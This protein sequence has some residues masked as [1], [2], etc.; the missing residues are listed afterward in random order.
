MYFAKICGLNFTMYHV[1]KN[2]F[3]KFLNINAQRDSI[4]ILCDSVFKKNQR[5]MQKHWKQ[6]PTDEQTVKTLQEALQIHPT[7]CELLAQRG[8]HDFEAARTYFRPELK[9]LHDPYEML[10]MERAVQRILQAIE[11]QEKI[12]IYGDYDV[13]GTT[14]VALMYSFLA[15]VHKHLDYYIPDRYKEGYGLSYQGIEYAKQK[16][17]GLLIT[18]DCGIR[19]TSEVRAAQHE[20]IDVIICDHH[21][22]GETLPE[23]HAILDPKQVDCAYPYKE[24][25]G[26]G[27]GF[28]LVQ[29][30]C[31][32][33]ELPN[34]RWL[35]LMDFLVISIAADIVPITGEN[36]ILAH[37]G[38][39]Q[40]NRTERIGL[41][42]LAGKGGKTFPLSISDIVFGIAPIVNAAGRLADAEQAVRLLLANTKQ[43]AGDLAN[44]LELR[45]KMRREFDERTSR[46]AKE[47]FEQLPDKES[48][49]S[50]CLFHPHWHKGV[51][52]ITASRMVEAFY[53]P[54]IILTESNGKVVGSARSVRHFNVYNAIESCSDLLVNFGGHSHAAGLTLYPEN[55]PAFQDRFEA[56]VSTT[57][58]D[59]AL[60]PEILVSSDLDLNTLTAA[61]WRILKQFAPFGPK[62]RNPIFVSKG[63]RDA[64]YTK[65]LRGNHLRL[66]IRHGQSEIFY[67]IAFGMGDFYAQVKTGKSFDICYSIHENRWKEKKYLQLMVK[68]IRFG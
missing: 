65:V 25:S 20:G 49:K 28:K 37:F 54:T 5:P 45:N 35:E 60:V 9:N 48:R 67:G 46:E 3:Y 44:I 4:K 59:S 64:G 34:E 27:V 22:P 47:Q 12:L 24:L 18:L 43:G 23:A 16:G 29:A 1:A 6:I 55:V 17:I 21:I 32:R 15:G 7:F 13:D 63:V 68:D 61:F 11:Q 42:A 33:L 52:G 62:N 40:L 36:R 8:I 58:E 41:R 26:C 30:L 19:A 2:K 39:E 14:S 57:I 51:V 53:R 56:T 38:L 66:A 50:I 31:Q 10:G